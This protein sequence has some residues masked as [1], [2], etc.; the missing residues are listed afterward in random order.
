M[1]KKFEPFREFLAL[2]SH[3]EAASPPSVKGKILP[4]ANYKSF[5]AIEIGDW[6]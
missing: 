4:A 1:L 6:Q 3:M 5:E 2:N